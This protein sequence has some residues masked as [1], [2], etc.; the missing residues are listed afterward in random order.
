MKWFLIGFVCLFCSA[1]WVQEMRRAISTIKASAR[2]RTKNTPTRRKIF[3]SIITGYPT[4]PNIDDV[5]IRAGYC[6]FLRGELC[7]RRSIDLATEA[8]ATNKPQFRATAL[9]FT[10]LA[11]FTEGQKSTDK[12]QATS[13]FADS[14]KTLTTLIDLCTTRRRRTTRAIWS[15]RF[16]IARWPNFCRTTTAGGKGPAEP[17]SVSA[18]HGEPEPA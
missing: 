6:L 17:G 15:S 13:A 4:S 5:R 1:T 16:I 7:P 8:N 3:D 10:A 18:I 14:A 2:C 11:Q 12:S 9:Y